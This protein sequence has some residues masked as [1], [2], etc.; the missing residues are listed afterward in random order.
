MLYLSWV[1][2]LRSITKLK[3][4][5][6]ELIIMKR[7]TLTNLLTHILAAVTVVAAM[8]SCAS[9]TS[10]L[11]KTGDPEAIYQRAI[12]LYQEEEW[13]KAASL[14]DATI[15][16][17]SGSMREDTVQ[18]Y[19][20][21]S[22]FKNNDFETAIQQLDDF[23]RRFGRSVFI[24]DAEGMYTLGHYYICPPETRDQQA[25]HTAIIAIDEF[26]SRYPDSMQAESFKEMKSE[27]VRRIHDK[28][29]L[30]AYTYYKIGKYKSA[31]VAFKNAMK[32]YPESLVREKVSYYIVAS[33]FKLAD[34][35]VILKKEDRFITMLDNYISFVSEFPE[36]EYRQEVD[37]M[38]RKA[39]IYLTKCD[40]ERKEREA[41]EEQQNKEEAL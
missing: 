1:R 2:R 35:S 9:S 28:E 7:V 32:K 4:N 25:S 5:R 15:P 13:K 40:E 11:V 34:N 6:E 36:S 33:A 17:Y 41:K 16:Y 23:R 31:I 20:A 8:S 24:E 14:F 37:D 21:R 26:L 30:N 27:L 22:R 18:F 29:F 39:R 10:R 12:T 38:E 19:S 3:I